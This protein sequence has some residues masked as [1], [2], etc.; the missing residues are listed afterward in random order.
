MQSGAVGV[1]SL[2][3]VVGPDGPSRAALR[4]GGSGAPLLL[5]RAG[6]STTAYGI[7]D[8]GQVVGTM[9]N[10]NGTSSAFLLSR[11]GG[12]VDAKT[13]LAPASNTT[14]A[15]PSQHH[16]QRRYFRQRDG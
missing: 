12:V 13:L 10:S 4:Q 2:C 9:G 11:A 7:N 3:T 6:S 1:N 5:T 14:L 8:A 16:R 15:P